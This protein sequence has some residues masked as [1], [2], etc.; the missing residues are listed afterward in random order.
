MV[1]EW[2][3]PLAAVAAALAFL[4]A[5]DAGRAGVSTA[6]D[7]NDVRGKLD[8]R[9]VSQ[10][11]AGT[12]VVHT[13]RTFSNWRTGLLAPRTPNYL[14]LEL[15]I[16]SDRAPE[17]SVLVFSQSGRM[18]GAL[19][20]P[21]G[22]FIALTRVTRPNRH[23]VRVTI[24]RNRLRNPGAY[25]W[26]AFAFFR[27]AN[28]CRGRGGCLDRAPNGGGRI[29]HDLRRPTI[30]FPPPTPP[31]SGTVEY[32]VGFT[33]SDTGGSGLARWRLQH[34]P[35][36]TA[37]WATVV[38]GTDAGAQTRHYVSTAG[39]Q[40]QFRVVAVDGHGNTAASPIRTVAVPPR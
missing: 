8:I 38:T 24:A 39:A 3:R 40:D 25:R 22:R 17:R 31:A 26:Q 7:P 1:V 4:V 36:G 20:G 13:I 5:A 29:L 14:L 18:V 33:V 16:D 34:R 12:R 11:H 32:D 10:G 9:S 2:N 23:T 15:N 37:A 28:V 19:F 27:G 21:R 35:Q 30:A 6:Q